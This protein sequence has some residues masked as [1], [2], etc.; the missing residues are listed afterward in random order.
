MN[1]YVHLDSGAEPA[2]GNVGAVAMVGADAVRVGPA[3]KAGADMASESAGACPAGH[4]CAAADAP[5]RSTQAGL[6]QARGAAVGGVSGELSA[7]AEGIQS[8]AWSADDGQSW[9]RA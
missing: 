1:W 9:L 8:P 7:N 2:A 6:G 5:A 4:A 3:R